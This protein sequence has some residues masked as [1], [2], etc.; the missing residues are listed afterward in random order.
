MRHYR[1]AD[2]DSVDKLLELIAI[3]KGMTN[4][5]EKQVEAEQKDAKKK[6]K[7]AKTVTQIENVPDKDQAARRILRD[8]L[9]NRLSFFSKI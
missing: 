2:F 1:I 7:G 6:K 3:K 8:F 4:A 9:N 5:V